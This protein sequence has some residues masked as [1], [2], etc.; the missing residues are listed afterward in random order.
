MP[1]TNHGASCT[2]VC[3]HTIIPKP[4]ISSGSDDSLEKPR[5]F[6]FHHQVPPNLQLTSAG[7]KEAAQTDTL[8]MNAGPVDLLQLLKGYLS[9]TCV[10][11]S[12]TSMP[13]SCDRSR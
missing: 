12:V 7:S 3:Q 13:A 9:V 2:G 4:R 11:L 5:R 1:T 10:S 8:D 6:L